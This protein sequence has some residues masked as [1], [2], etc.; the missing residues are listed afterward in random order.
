MQLKN[1]KS[2]HDMGDGKI[3]EEHD[4]AEDAMAIIVKTTTVKI[5][6]QKHCQAL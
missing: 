5:E 2:K 6:D 4:D 1:V 3:E